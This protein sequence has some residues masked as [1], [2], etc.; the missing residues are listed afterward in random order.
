LIPYDE[1]LGV[2]PQAEGFTN[3]ELWDFEHTAPDQYPLLLHFTYFDLYRK[4]VVKQPD[5]VMAML[6][7]AHAFTPEQVERNFEYYERITVRDSSL[8]A[9]IEATVAAQTDHLRLAFDYAAEA[10]L[11]DLQD[12]EHNVAD[13]LHMA[14]LAGAWI[15][16]VVGLG[17][18]R[19]QREYLAFSPKLPDGLTRYAFTITRRDRQL[20]VNVTATHAD[21]VLKSPGTLEIRHYGEQLTV[22]DTA[23]V[24]R[25]IPPI[26][27][28]EPPQQPAGRGPHRRSPG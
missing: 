22:T 11:I 19:D 23:P 1:R 5:L 28:R 27:P 7:C 14:S 3:H 17:G 4:Q 18:M 9:T 6:T 10:T 24:S 20:H 13:G 12:L 2:H 25:P 21:Y 26:P 15:A 8:S 16:F